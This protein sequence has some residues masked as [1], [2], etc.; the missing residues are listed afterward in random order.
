M[1]IRLLSGSAIFILNLHS[2]EIVQTVWLVTVF[3][4]G[5]EVLFEKKGIV[6]EWSHFI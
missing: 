2:N 6:L 4:G 5:L 3:N 1:L